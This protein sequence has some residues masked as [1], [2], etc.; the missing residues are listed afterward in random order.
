M[1]NAISTI[2]N[3][4]LPSQDMTYTWVE[5]QFIY[6]FLAGIVFSLAD[7]SFKTAF[8]VMLI[9]GLMFGRLLHRWGGR[10]LPYFTF[11][12][13]GFSLGYIL[14]MPEKLFLL[15]TYF[16]GITL[17]YQLHKNKVVESVEW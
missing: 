6:L 17:A 2:L 8:V 13:L 15:A 14:F 1:A 11:I 3:P 12:C 16:V 4:I 9:A 10:L 7:I 5:W